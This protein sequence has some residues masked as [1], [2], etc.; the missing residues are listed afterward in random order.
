MLSLP[1]RVIYKENT[2]IVQMDLHAD[3]WDVN[4]LHKRIIR[5]LFV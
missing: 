4:P 3:V 5:F 1:V 2:D